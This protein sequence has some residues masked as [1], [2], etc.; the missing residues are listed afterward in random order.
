V[1]T[2]LFLVL[3]P[4]V[5]PPA[6]VDAVTINDDSDALIVAAI[7]WAREQMA[8]G[9][10][11]RMFVDVGLEAAERAGMATDALRAH[12]NTVARVARENSIPTATMQGHAGWQS[13]SRDVMS[14]GC[15]TAVGTT[16][17]RVAR[18]QLLSSHSANV[19]VV[20]WRITGQARPASWA[21]LQQ[22][23]LK[24]RRSEGRWEVVEAT[25]GIVGH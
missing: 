4:V 11:A 23:E 15:Q 25:R 20:L 19:S 6:L 2:L 21:F 7:E 12:T 17:V 3:A 1:V 10:R 8:P 18:L 13:C 9:E 16:A 5:P 24:L 14:P 22:W